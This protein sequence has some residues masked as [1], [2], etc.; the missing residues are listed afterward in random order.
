MI[1]MMANSLGRDAEG[2]G[3]LS[4][5]VIAMDYAFRDPGIGYSV[6][7][8]NVEV[9]LDGGAIQGTYVETASG[10]TV[11]FLLRR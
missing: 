3:V 2:R 1:R 10:V 9:S 4:G 11:P 7:R 5:R 6:G 8:A